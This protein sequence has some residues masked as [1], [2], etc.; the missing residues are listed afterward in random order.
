MQLT[1]SVFTNQGPIPT[2]YASAGKDSNPPLAI[3][4]APQGT[5]AFAL[6]M[7]DPD[8]MQSDYLHWAMWNIPAGTTTIAEGEVPQGAVVGIN[9]AQNF[10]YARPMP[11]A[12]SGMHRYTFELYALN[13]MLDVPQNADRTAI[14]TAINAHTIQKAQLVGLYGR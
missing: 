2:E 12:G 5:I 7:H 1:S 11:P 3:A 6:V 13:A 8:A 10:G 9:D 14:E 4:Q